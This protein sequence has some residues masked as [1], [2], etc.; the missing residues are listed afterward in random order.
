MKYQD[1]KAE[2]GKTYYYKVEILVKSGKKILE[3]GVSKA[4]SGKTLKQ[5]SITS[6]TA[7]GTAM[8][9]KW[10]K[11]SGADG[12]EIFRSTKKKGT[13]EKIGTVTGAKKT[14]YEDKTLST[15]KT[16]YYKVRA[17]H[18]SKKQTETGSFSK[19]FKTFTLKKVTITSAAADGKKVNLAWEK[20][21]KGT[22]YSI[23]R[24]EQG[25]NFR[26]DRYDLFFE[27]SKIY[28]FQCRVW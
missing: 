18:K 11:V 15:G 23:Y 19:V 4:A 9:L 17:Y 14:K 7:N 8:L 2:A 26:T 21:D 1:K 27:K 22:G 6:V 5:V 28:G 16:Y 10:K 24:S 3:N 20:A 25:R 13:Y 12:Y